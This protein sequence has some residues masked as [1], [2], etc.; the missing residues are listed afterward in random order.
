MLEIDISN[1]SGRK[2]N[3]QVKISSFQSV[4]GMSHNG[5]VMWPLVCVPSLQSDSSVR[6]QRSAALTTMTAIHIANNLPP[7]KQAFH[8]PPS[9]KTSP[10]GS[11]HNNTA[12]SSTH[13]I[14]SRSSTDNTTPPKKAGRSPTT[15]RK[16]SSPGAAATVVHIQKSPPTS[17]K[18]LHSPTQKATT[19]RK[20]TPPISI[21][22]ET[23]HLSEQPKIN[24]QPTILLPK[25]IK[26]PPPPLPKLISE[27]PVIQP[28]KKSPLL[29]PSLKPVS[30]LPQPKAD[31]GSEKGRKGRYITIPSIEY[32]V[33]LLPV[34]LYMCCTYAGVHIT[35]LPVLS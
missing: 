6:P 14:V 17:E 3:Y 23:F 29:S 32:P 8:K 21:P 16:N 24:I 26:A 30:K 33:S 4:S 5:T 22:K 1:Q 9:H 15:G 27:P 35:N 28:A 10:Q 18:N 13:N 31:G 25:A 34:Y 11:A 2:N 7:L 20:T 19:P 12:K